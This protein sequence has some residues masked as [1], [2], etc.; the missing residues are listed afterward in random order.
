MHA[1]YLI[2]YQLFNMDHPPSSLSIPSDIMLS[3]L[4]FIHHVEPE[5]SASGQKPLQDPKSTEAAVK[6]VASTIQTT[7]EAPSPPKANSPPSH[8]LSWTP[9]ASAAEH[10]LQA[11]TE[12]T[13]SKLRIAIIMTLLCFCVFV[14]AID[15]TIIST[16]LSS[17]SVALHSATGYQW[18][19]SSY[20]LGNTASTPSWGKISDIFG[21]KPILLLAIVI[22]FVGSLI[23][24]LAENIAM[25]LAGRGIQGIGGSGF[26][27]LVN[28]AISDLF[29]LRDRSVYYG[30]SS[31]VWAFA[32][33]VGPILGGVF[34]QQLSWVHLIWSIPKNSGVIGL[35]LRI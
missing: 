16:A 26:L 13:P 12:S 32:G 23:C 25:L 33:G 10:E 3:T 8:V 21:R 27:T 18:I 11:R 20:V 2:F 34:A 28:I 6:A 5:S 22:F 15:I 14:A 29:S 17:I 30:L 9:E 35:F 4:T 19:A 24:A 1:I 7:P 31:V